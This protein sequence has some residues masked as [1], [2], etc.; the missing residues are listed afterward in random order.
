MT[1]YV[2]R[3][4][5]FDT[6]THV[7]AIRGPRK[8]H[9]ES[10]SLAITG[11][12]VA[13]TSTGTSTYPGP[14]PAIGTFYARSVVFESTTVNY[15]VFVPSSAVATPPFPVVLSL[16]S[17]AERHILNLQM[18][19]SGVLP[20]YLGY[21]NNTL[22][23]SPF[24]VNHWPTIGIFPQVYNAGNT[25]NNV[26]AIYA[27]QGAIPLI[28]AATKAEWHC[29]NKRFGLSG[30]SAG[31]VQLFPLIWMMP[32]QFA[33]V[34]CM[35]ATPAKAFFR[36]QQLPGWAPT[37]D[38]T[39]DQEAVDFIVPIMVANGITFRMYHGS[40]DPSN[41]ALGTALSPSIAA[42]YAAAGISSKYTYLVDHPAAQQPP[43][44][45]EAFDHGICWNREMA[46]ANGWLTDLFTIAKP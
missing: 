41:T 39:T 23:T 40:L 46:Y 30:Q 31:G 20:Q 42:Y 33:W 25:A 34:Q 9:V 35:S 15:Q 1:N 16:H 24:G 37:P 28:I 21:P 7:R 38:L 18:S 22:S 10:T 17:A 19:A 43:S 12:D 5:P 29:D 3:V 13:L 26:A 32:T 4:E 45:G 6:R 8:L 36:A 27:T 44:S 14:L 11:N 2:L